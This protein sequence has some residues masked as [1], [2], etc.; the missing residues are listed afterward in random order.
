[1]EYS[2]YS[3]QVWSERRENTC[4]H[5]TPPTLTRHAQMK[6]V[7]GDLKNSNVL[8]QP[9]TSASR[10][11]RNHFYTIEYYVLWVFLSFEWGEKNIQ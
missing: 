11:D 6:P 4:T 3:P 9:K 1:M 2:E 5:P 8:S 7:P 10:D